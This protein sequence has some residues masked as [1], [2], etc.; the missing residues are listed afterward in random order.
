[1]MKMGLLKTW[2]GGLAVAA[3]AVALSATPASA[4][5]ADACRCVDRDGNEAELAKREAMAEERATRDD[6]KR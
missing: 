6:G 1:M 2:S 3:L 4:Q 5:A